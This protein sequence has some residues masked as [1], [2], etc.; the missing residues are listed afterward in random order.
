ME[1]LL[2]VALILLAHGALGSWVAS[3]KRRS[4]LEGAILGLLFGPLGVLVEALLPQGEHQ[5]LKKR[6]MVTRVRPEPVFTERP[7]EIPDEWLK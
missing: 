2:P 4:A 7:D 5:V 6:P 1:W 3:Q